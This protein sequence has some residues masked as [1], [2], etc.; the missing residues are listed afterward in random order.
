MY[1]AIIN[2]TTRRVFE[3]VTNEAASLEAMQAYNGE[4]TRCPCSQE[5]FIAYSNGKE[6]DAPRRFAVKTNEFG[7]KYDSL[8][9]EYTVH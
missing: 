6:I 2:K 3:V 9:T 1:I 8:I 5:E 4:A 7:E